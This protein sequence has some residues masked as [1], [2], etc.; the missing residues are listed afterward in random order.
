MRKYYSDWTF[1]DNTQQWIDQFGARYS[2]DRKTLIGCRQSFVGRFNI[3][4]GVEK[5]EG[6]AF[7]DCTVLDEI[8][9]PDTVIANIPCLYL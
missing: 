9:I 4:Y 1:D 2:E 3:P 5:I 6:R 7:Y 8:Y